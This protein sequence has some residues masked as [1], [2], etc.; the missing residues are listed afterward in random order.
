VSADA[1]GRFVVAWSSEDQDGDEFGVFAQ[2]VDSAGNPI[3]SEFQVNSETLYTQGYQGVSVAS[4]AGGDFVVAWSSY[5]QDG[6]GWGVFAQRFDA[7]GAPAGAEFQVNTHTIADQGYGNTYGGVVAAKSA[8]GSFVVAWASYY[9]DGY[10]NGVF[11]RHFDNTGAPTSATDFQVP[12]YTTDN[13]GAYGG[14]GVAGDGSGNFVVS[15][16]SYDQDGDYFGVFA[17]RVDSSGTPVGVDFQVN[18]YTP[19]PQ[20]F[21]GPS[22]AADAAGNFTIVWASGAQDGSPGF[23][24]FGQRFLSD[25]TPEGGE[26]QS[27]TYVPGHQWFPS[28]SADWGGCSV[29]VWRSGVRSTPQNCLVDTDCPKFPLEKCVSQMCSA[30]GQQDGFE[31]GIFAQRY[32][33]ARQHDHYK[34]YKAKDHDTP[35]FRRLNVDLV[36]QFVSEPVTVLAP[37]LLCTPVDK[38]GEGINDPAVHQCCYKVKAPRLSPRPTV[39]VASQFQPSTLD[40][41]VPKLLCT[42]CTK[43]VL[44]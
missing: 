27:N 25:A 18:T 44:P 3:G 19:G 33:E 32:C 10:G 9:Q 29:V 5:Y 21:A 41:V 24:V 37:F 26:F 22:V 30:V 36:D 31:G 14:L 38:S 6:Y 34:C 43:T 4:G 15:W 23:G 40:V 13:E 28:V 39:E 16:T 11:A 35:R 42:P 17:R 12:M 1:S 20:G 8:S 7:A 2:R